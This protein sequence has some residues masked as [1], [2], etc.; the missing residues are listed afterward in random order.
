VSL[1]RYT[2][3]VSA[4]AASSLL[5]VWGV[6]PHRLDAMD[7]WAALYGGTLALLNTVGAYFL[8]L[9]SDR[10]PTV[11]FLRTVLW[12]TLGRMMALLVGVV[13][14]ILALGLPRMP[15][16]VS[17]LAYFLVFFVIQTTILHRR[18]PTAPR[19]AL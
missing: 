16:I 3:V 4:V 5:L 9:W 15:L 10:R 8:V 18:A 13:V 6:G 2:F 11:V 7:R 1:S 19:E 17:L 12:G 14:G